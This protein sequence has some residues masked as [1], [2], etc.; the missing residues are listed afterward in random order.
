[1]PQ[2]SDG[3]RRESTARQN[4]D[5]IAVGEEWSSKDC[6]RDGTLLVLLAMALVDG[7]LFDI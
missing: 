2:K 5:T 1:M 4:A 6:F 3:R 7:V